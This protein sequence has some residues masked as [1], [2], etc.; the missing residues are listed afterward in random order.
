MNP[1]PN[2]SQPS[3][4]AVSIRNR[5]V[6]LT[7]TALLGCTSGE[8]RSSVP[9]L[10]SNAADSLTLSSF[11]ASQG[12]ESLPLRPLATGHFAL[13]GTADAIVLTLIVVLVAT[14]PLIT[15]PVYL[16]VV[17]RAIVFAIV[18]L[19]MNMLVGYT[20][21]ISLGH[22]A[23]FGVGA[24]G[25]GYAL[26]ELALP[27]AAGI[28]VAILTGAVAALLLGGIAL[29]IRGL[30]LALVTIAYGLFVQEVVFNIRGLTGG[31]A[32][33]QAPRP[34]FASGDVA[35]VYL[36]LAVLLAALVFDWRLMASRAGRA[37]RALRD[38]ERVAASWGINVTAYKLLAFTIS[39][40]LA[41]LA[42]GLFASIEGVVVA[43][44]FPLQLSL[45]FLVMTVI[46]GA[47]NRW[48]VVQGSVVLAVLPTLL[49]WSHVNIGVWPFT[50][51]TATFEPVVGAVLLLL[52]LAF[53]P[54]G[55]AQQQQHLLSWLTFKRFRSHGED[56]ALTA[57]GGHGRA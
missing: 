1:I 22:A 10:D 17:A 37:I 40:V 36:C 16:N 45:T 7:L 9:N 42:G 43:A 49:D 32:G 6:C 19:S 4:G 39:G 38:D 11:L 34:A 56:P 28:G 24:F 13:D 53:F 30:Y 15:S 27:F 2:V 33:M 18:G 12:Y 55:I 25:A 20:G 5:L 26:T 48:G 51:M 23:F 14:V 41:A 54:G 3:G 31:G 8:E 35:Y 21:Q 46:G 47:G 52:T 29:R 57:G 44:D 50:V